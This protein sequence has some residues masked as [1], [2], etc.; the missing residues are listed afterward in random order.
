VW[1]YKDGEKTSLLW[2]IFGYCGT[3]KENMSIDNP[4]ISGRKLVDSR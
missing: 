2:L 1:G 4:Q 3:D